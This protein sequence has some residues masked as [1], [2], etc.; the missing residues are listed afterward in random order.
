[1]SCQRCLET[2]VPECAVMK[3]KGINRIG[4]TF[5]HAGKVYDANM[6]TIRKLFLGSCEVDGCTACIRVINAM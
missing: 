2:I 6:A 1:M 4:N 5:K 3:E